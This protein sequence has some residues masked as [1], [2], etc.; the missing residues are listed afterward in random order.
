MTGGLAA[1]LITDNWRFVSP[2]LR[3]ARNG[4]APVVAED[5]DRTAVEQDTK[6]HEPSLRG[7]RGLNVS[8]TESFGGAV[9]YRRAATLER[10]GPVVLDFGLDVDFEQL[11]GGNGQLMLLD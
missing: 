9:A 10:E 8:T 3:G 5:L 1:A 7:E 11:A 2:V 4:H 6:P